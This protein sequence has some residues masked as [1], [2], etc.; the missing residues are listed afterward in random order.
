MPREENQLACVVFMLMTCSLLEP[1]RF[2]R[3]S[4]KLSKGKGNG[5]GKGKGMGKG[6]REGKGMGRGKGEGKGEKR[7]ARHCCSSLDDNVQHSLPGWGLFAFMGVARRWGWFIYRVEVSKQGSIIYLLSSYHDLLSQFVVT[8]FGMRL[9]PMTSPFVRFLIVFTFSLMFSIFCFYSN[10]FAT[11]TPDPRELDREET[12][13]RTWP[14][15]VKLGGHWPW[16]GPNQ[17]GA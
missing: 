6:K 10:R 12:S 2:W 3:S 1:Q 4:R 15:Q 13:G 9:F 11:T 7:N 17:V 5:R 16:V 8:F 14:N